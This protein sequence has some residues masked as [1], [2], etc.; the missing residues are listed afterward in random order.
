MGTGK[1][2]LLAKLRSEHPRARFLNVGHRVNLMKNLSERL[3]TQ[4]YSEISQGQLAKALSLS[5]T[6]DS[7][8]KLQTQYNEYDC[9][10]IDEA[11]QNLAHLLH[12]NTC[13]EH[14]AEILEVLEYIIGK[15]KLVVLADAHMND[16]TVDFFRA[17]RPLGEVPF[18]IKEVHQKTRGDDGSSG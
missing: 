16:V 13:K 4:M 18:I 2:E 10:F 1:T 7:L 17:M 11:C 8:Y 15:A 12:S 5:I 3:S 9:V 6:L 14:R